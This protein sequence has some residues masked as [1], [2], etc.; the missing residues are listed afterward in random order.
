MKVDEETTASDKSAEL[1][2]TGVSANKTTINSGSP[3]LARWFW[4]SIILMAVASIVLSVAAALRLSDSG[5]DVTGSPPSMNGG[6][7]DEPVEQS[8][9]E[10]KRRLEHVAAITIRD[11]H[12]G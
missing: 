10:L 5:R 7:S 8:A 9:S 2:G 6:R 3:N 1:A 12:R 4:G 11:S